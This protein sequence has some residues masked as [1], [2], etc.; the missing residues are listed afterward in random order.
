MTNVQSLVARRALTHSIREE[1]DISMKLSSGNRIYQAA[2]DPAGLA[3]SEGL[4][5]KSR[6]LSQAKRNA[7]DGISLLQ[8]A[9]GTMAAIHNVTGRLRE[10]SMQAA[11]GTL[12]DHE[13]VIADK[14][15]QSMKLEI[16]RMTSS[17]SFNGKNILG[18]NSGVFDLQIGVNNNA[19]TDR[20]SYNMNE[21]LK[22]LES[23]GIA[24]SNIR[25]QES[26]R[27]NLAA[28]DRMIGAVSG[29]RATLG[30]VQKRM[31]SVIQNL[32]ISKESTESSKSQIRD[33]DIAIE[34]TNSTKGSIQKD[35][36]TSLLAQ[37]NNLPRHIQK[38]LD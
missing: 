15:F 1:E 6:G 3:I 34:T 19:S 28:V 25:T 35:I 22:S 17:A 8:V 10:L 31:E 18:A 11:N 20:I 27:Q 7:N 21:A 12:T 33:T 9:E 2:N 16:S 26:S 38:L 5:A 13:R 29:S 23:F 37:A 14:E 36:N 4:R 32:M 30:S 24:S